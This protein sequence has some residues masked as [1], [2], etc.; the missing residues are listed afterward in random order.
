MLRIS[1]IY[2]F[3]VRDSGKWMVYFGPHPHMNA[4]NPFPS[5]KISLE[6]DLFFPQSVPFR[7]SINWVRNVHTEARN[8][9]YILKCPHRC[10]NG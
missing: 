4:R 7:L 5:L 1:E 3:Q 9:L 2:N 8:L 6:R 10:T